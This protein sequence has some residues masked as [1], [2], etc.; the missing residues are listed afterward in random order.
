MLDRHKE[1]AH[2]DFVNSLQIQIAEMEKREESVLS[3]LDLTRQQLSER[4]EYLQMMTDKIKSKTMEI[5]QKQCT[6]FEYE[7]RL[8]ICYDTIR[9]LEARNQSADLT[10]ESLERQLSARK[11]LMAQMERKEQ[12]FRLLLES[13]QKQILEKEE[14]L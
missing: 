12:S 7:E 3:A 1:L 10:V 6:L 8:Q 13:L 5:K 9:K 4:D 11:E 14:Q 2:Q